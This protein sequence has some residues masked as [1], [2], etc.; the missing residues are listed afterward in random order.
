MARCDAVK[1]MGPDELESFEH[2]TFSAWSC[3]SLGDLGRAVER[4]P[5]ELAG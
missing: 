5:K 1:S 4:R 3:A 2:R